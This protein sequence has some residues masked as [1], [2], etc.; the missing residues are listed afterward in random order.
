MII[1]LKISFVYFCFTL[2]TDAQDWVLFNIDGKDLEDITVAELKVRNGINIVDLN[3][4]IETV[5]LIFKSST[6]YTG[7]LYYRYKGLN[8]KVN[9]VYIPIKD[10]FL[11]LK[12]K[13]INL[14]RALKIIKQL[15]VIFFDKQI[16]KVSPE[17]LK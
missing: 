12:N 11:I 8:K 4:K 16:K 2:L 6:G 17:S 7:C 15:G 5:H 9:L 3:S 13:K 14:N 1:L 10:N